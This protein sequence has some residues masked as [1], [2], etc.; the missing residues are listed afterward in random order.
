MHIAAFFLMVSFI[1]TNPLTISAQPLYISLT[2]TNKSNASDNQISTDINTIHKHTDLKTKKVS[3]H[4]PNKNSKAEPKQ[5]ASEINPQDVKGIQDINEEN[6]S[7]LPLESY[8]P[9]N[10][11]ELIALPTSNLDSSLFEDQFISG[12]PIKL[13]LYINAFGRVVKIDQYD[14]L[15]QDIPMANR[16]EDLLKQMSFLPAKK[17]GINVDSYQDIEF[18]F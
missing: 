16:L 15:A 6:L 3:T 18:S 14:V 12:L 1:E 2:T 4:Q 11:V 17:D 5:E 9:P 13:R 8:Y 7:Q 10:N